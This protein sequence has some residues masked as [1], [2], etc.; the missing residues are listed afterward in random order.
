MRGENPPLGLITLDQPLFLGQFSTTLILSMI[1]VRLK[2]SDG[3]GVGGGH[4]IIVVS[5][6]IQIRI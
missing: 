4:I 2:K 3:T 5:F 6:N 1:E